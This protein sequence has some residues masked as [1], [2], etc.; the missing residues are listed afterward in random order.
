MNKKKA[1]VFQG[2]QLLSAMG[3][4]SASILLHFNFLLLI[5]SYF[6]NKQVVCRFANSLIQ[7]INDHHIWKPNK[8]CRIL[9]TAFTERVVKQLSKDSVRLYRL[10]VVY[11]HWVANLA[12]FFPDVLLY[13][14]LIAN[15]IF[16]CKII[17][18]KTW[19]DYFSWSCVFFKKTSDAGYVSK[20]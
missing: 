1:A 14:I 7:V 3:V 4:I 11:C 17:K 8:F 6:K 13:L 5:N 16:T 18:V 9:K 19:C 15:K 2:K 20:R 12:K 10:D